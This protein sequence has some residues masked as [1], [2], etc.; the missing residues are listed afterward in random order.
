M[1]TLI[2]SIVEI[3]ACALAAT[4]YAGLS[5]DVIPESSRAPARVGMLFYVLV[6][7]LARLHQ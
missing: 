7:I 5:L 1:T 4:L 6:A 2:A 3:V